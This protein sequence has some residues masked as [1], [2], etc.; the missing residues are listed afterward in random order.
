MATAIQRKSYNMHYKATFT[1]LLALGANVGSRDEERLNNH[2]C[3]TEFLHIMAFNETELDQFYAMAVLNAGAMLTPMFDELSASLVRFLEDDSRCLQCG[4]DEVSEKMIQLVVES[5][6]RIVSKDAVTSLFRY[7]VELLFNGYSNTSHESWQDVEFDIILSTENH[8]SFGLT[9]TH[10]ENRSTTIAAFGQGQMLTSDTDEIWEG[11]MR[12]VLSGF[13]FG[14]GRAYADTMAIVNAVGERICNFDIGDLVDGHA[15]GS[16]YE[17]IFADEFEI[18][19]EKFSAERFKCETCQ[20]HNPASR[21]DPTWETVVEALLNIGIPFR[22]VSSFNGTGP[23]ELA[24]QKVPLPLLDMLW[25]S[26]ESF[27]LSRSNHFPLRMQERILQC[28]IEAGNRSVIGYLLKELLKTSDV[29][30]RS[31][32]DFALQH[33]Y[34]MSLQYILDTISRDGLVARRSS[35]DNGSGQ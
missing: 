35:F 25:R 22:I 23:I 6:G 31:I 1:R 7:F 5:K 28:A 3:N 13:L 27:R 34:T 32:L 21:H 16:A 12:P 29:P 2:E 4:Y 17:R 33:T 24:A 10:L 20:C 8:V 30:C 14:P 19:P 11:N 15:Q 9:S 18:K 26:A